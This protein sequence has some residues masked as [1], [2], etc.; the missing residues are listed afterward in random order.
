MRGIAVDAL[1]SLNR[2]TVRQLRAIGADGVR[3]VYFDDPAWL[4]Y[5]KAVRKAGLSVAV[6]LT[7]ESFGED[8]AE[9]AERYVEAVGSDPPVL[10]LL[11]NEPNA[12]AGSA[13]SWVLGAGAAARIWD[14]V[15]PVILRDVGPVYLGGILGPIADPA[16]ASWLDRF[17]S[18]VMTAPSGID[19]HYPD[20]EADVA[21]WAQWTRTVLGGGLSVMEWCW[22]GA[23]V[24]RQDVVDWQRM[25]SRYATHTAWF[26]WSNS[27]VPGMGLVGAGG[28][29]LKSWGDYREALLTAPPDPGG[30]TV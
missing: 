24:P 8:Y 15:A 5:Y 22:S 16:V 20:S 17:L 11:L 9:T 21:A 4:A 23:H 2:P 7:G 26:C 14:S 12:P 13:S 25:L 27:V 10:T 30:A 28:R 1:N 6:V 3:L 29:K 18:A 19:I